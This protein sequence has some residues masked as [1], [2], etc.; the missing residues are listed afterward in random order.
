MTST[1]THTRVE[2]FT[3]KAEGYGLH[4]VSVDG[5]DVLA[6]YESVMNATTVI[7]AGG[8]VGMVELCYPCRGDHGPHFAR[9]RGGAGDGCVT[10]AKDPILMFRNRLIDGGWA[11][12]EE[13]DALH[14]GVVEEVG[15][16]AEQAMSEPP[17]VGVAA[18][19]DVYTDLRISP[20]WTRAVDPDPRRS[21][22]RESTL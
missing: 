12:D 20:P 14:A 10:Q 3:E 15:I 17:P 7:R 22:G 19:A 5:T 18:A 4:A 1:S 16:A 9:E 11:M 2:S 21:T 6:V 13:L 8:G